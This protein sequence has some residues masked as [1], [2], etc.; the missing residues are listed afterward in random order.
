MPYRDNYTLN[1]YLQKI[2]QTCI[3]SILARETA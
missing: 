1:L 2:F 3:A